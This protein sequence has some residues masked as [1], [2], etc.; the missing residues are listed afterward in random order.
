VVVPYHGIGHYQ[1]TPLD[2][3]NAIRIKRKDFNVGMLVAEGEPAFDRARCFNDTD[4]P[5]SARYALADLKIG[6]E[7]SQVNSNFRLRIEARADFGAESERQTDTWWMGAW[8]LL[9]FALCASNHSSQVRPKN[10]IRS[11]ERRT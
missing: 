2:I 10:Q 4:C 8:R 1:L 11:V 6:L 3:T 5:Y 7:P 9:P